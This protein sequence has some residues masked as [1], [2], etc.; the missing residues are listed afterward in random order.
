M[1]SSGKVQKF[2]LRDMAVAELGVLYP[3][4]VETS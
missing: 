2:L 1:T 3:T 4:T